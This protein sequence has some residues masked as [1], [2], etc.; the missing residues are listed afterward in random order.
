MAATASRAVSARTSAQDTTPGH[1]SSTRVLTRSMKSKPRSDRFGGESFSAT[2]PPVELSR[3]GRVAALQEA[4]TD[5][6]SQRN[7]EMQLVGR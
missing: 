1:A 6:V 7:D 2:L 5:R 4:H 3:D